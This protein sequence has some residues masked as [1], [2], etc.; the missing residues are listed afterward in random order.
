MADP[1]RFA[2]TRWSLVLAAQ[3]TRDPDSDE[4]GG[5]SATRIF[6]DDPNPFDAS[7]GAS[8]LQV[9]WPSDHEGSEIDL[10]CN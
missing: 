8:P 1:N 3:N 10:N 6:A 7:C 4:E 2:T 9:C 5:G